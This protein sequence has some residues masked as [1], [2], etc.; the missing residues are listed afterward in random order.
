MI[1]E[2]LDRESIWLIQ[3]PQVFQYD[4]ILK[5]HETANRDGIIGTDDASL[6]ERLGVG[7]KIISGSKL[8]IKITIKED[9]AVAKAL[10]DAALI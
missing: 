5:A 3:T 9:L 1:K 6:V 2:T 4:L 10:F 7:V 8:N